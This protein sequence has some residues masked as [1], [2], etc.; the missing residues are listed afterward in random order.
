MTI[1][2]SPQDFNTDDLYVDLEPVVGNTLFLKV[3]GLNFAGSV[4]LKAASAM[5]EAAEADGTL[6][7]GAILVESSS[8]NLGI[9]LSMIAAAKG[10]GFVC[11]T[12]SRC[13][14][15]TRRLMES[16]G[17]EVHVITEPDPEHGLLGARLDHVR[18][19]LASDDRH[20]WLNQYTNPNSWKAHYDTTGPQIAA[21]F[22]DVDVI[23]IG[24]GTTGTLMGT[25]RY[26]ADHHPHVRIV[27]VDS[28]GSVSFGTPAARRMIP[29]LGMAVRPPL[30]DQT[31]IDEVVHVEEADT[32]RTCHRLARTGFLFG[33]STGTVVTAAEAWLAEHATPGTTA[34]A[35]APDLGERYMDTIYQS[36][37]VEDL[38]GDLTADTDDTGAFA[39]IAA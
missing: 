12:D 4:K 18:D 16:L 19:L 34:V 3:E 7:P 11:V 1:I 28:V 35:I 32:I 25:A 13:N 2:T 14:L 22:P 6:R 5:V 26:F 36:H 17:A 33:G 24:A 21:Q 30:L 39:A 15:A 20:V 29:G 31:V 9:A 27:A 8:G 38:Y 10:Y 37:W 23:F